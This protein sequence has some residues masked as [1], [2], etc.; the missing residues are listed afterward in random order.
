MKQYIELLKTIQ[1]KGTYK[2]A[3]RENM[4]GTQSL[5]GYQFRHNLADGFPLLTTKKISFKNVVT[6]LLWFLRGDTNIKYLVDNG[7]N[8]WNEDYEVWKGRV[9]VLEEGDL[10]YTYGHQWRRFG[11]DNE[12]KFQPKPKFTDVYRKQL[13]DTKESTSQYIGVVF[14]TKQGYE[15]KVID[16]DGINKYTVQFLH[17]GYVTYAYSKKQFESISY[18]YHLT[19]MGIAC[20]GIDQ[21]NLSKEIRAKLFNMWRAILGRCYDPNHIEYERYGKKGVYVSNEWLCFEFFVS[22]LLRMKN[23]DL[24][25]ENWKDFSLDKD[26]SRGKKYSKETCL[27]VSVKE[28]SS[29]RH[30]SI[31]YKL[32]NKI[33]GEIFTTN[34]LSD[35]KFKGVENVGSLCTALVKGKVKSIKGWELIETIDQT[36]RGIDQIKVL[37]EGLKNNPE[38][39]RHIVSSWN[40]IDIEN[41]Y[42][43]LP[44]CHAMFQFNCR[45]LTQ[46]E[47]IQWV[48]RN[49][50]VE[51]ENLYIF[52]ETL[53]S[54][55]PKYYLDC[56]LYQRSADSVLGVPYN[57]ASYALLTH[58]I[59]KIC[60]MIPGEFIH[61]FGDV[62]IYDNHREQVAEQLTREPKELPTLRSTT[63][64]NMVVKDGRDLDW[65]LSEIDDWDGLF[66]LE[67]Y[68]PEPTIK[69]ELST[70]LIK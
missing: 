46:E 10:G 3:A 21:Q 38:G 55:T 26:L 63:W 30:R 7:C 12:R 54:S 1:E 2:P 49:T 6:E 8:I 16:F 56:Q 5:F 27:W 23:W 67:N 41:G 37:I 52:E 57:I 29:R 20:V 60:N 70:G 24:K 18:P 51:L 19:V 33:S 68:N 42:M 65:I 43:A 48:M 45:P 28:N 35:L 25:L 58:I 14:K 4:P 64:F 47:K 62:H 15:I 32:K 66:I 22:D 11:E 34:C 39:R 17:S 69:A 61:S 59:A 44:A 13:I 36:N 31:F 40:P 9:N 53:K 50:D